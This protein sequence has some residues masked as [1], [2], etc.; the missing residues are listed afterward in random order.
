MAYDEELL[1]G[2]I[3]EDALRSLIDRFGPPAYGNRR[4]GPPQPPAPAPKELPDIERGVPYQRQ[5][6]PIDPGFGL[7]G[8]RPRPTLVGSAGE[9]MEDIFRTT[10]RIVQ[11]ERYRG[12]EVPMEEFDRR[13]QV[14]DP[15]EER[16]SYSS[17]NP[18]DAMRDIIE[19]NQGN[20]DVPLPMPRYPDMD[21]QRGESLRR[22][23]G[24]L[25]RSD[26]DRRLEEV[27]QADD[28]LGSVEGTYEHLKPYVA[29]GH[30][31]SDQELVDQIMGEPH[32]FEGVGQGTDPENPEPPT[33]RD[34]ELL[35]RNP[36]AV[37]DKFIDE[38]GP[39]AVPE[40][41]RPKN[42]PSEIR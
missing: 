11:G 7:Q 15:Y 26:V 20:P 18:D 19:H 12:R 8:S 38:F 41:L 42:L 25:K 29:P 40:D 17:P 4:L 9:P 16:Q 31:L 22:P 33:E 1:A 14:Y 28:V 32:P 10:P 5:Q 34:I 3:G 24:E 30:E 36:D 2:M 21:I 6:Q 37:L 13:P 23:L 27:L 39:D 35:R